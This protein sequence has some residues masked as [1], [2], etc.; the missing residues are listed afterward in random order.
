M[1]A[2]TAT[3]V[4]STRVRRSR[5]KLDVDGVETRQAISLAAPMS[6]RIGAPARR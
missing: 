6:E 2:T 4:N 5:K 3:V 1:K